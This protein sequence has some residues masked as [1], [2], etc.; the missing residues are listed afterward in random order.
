MKR[1]IG[2][3]LIE[4]LIVVAIIGILAAIAVPNFLEAQVRA[5]VARALADM[6]TMATGIETYNV[7]Y[8]T[9]PVTRR[10]EQR[11]SSDP[12]LFL[13]TRLRVLT[14]PIA[15]LATMP[16]EIFPPAAGWNGKVND[17]SSSLTFKSFDTYDYF[18]AESD[19][20]DYQY[21]VSKYSS[22][23]AINYDADSTRGCAWR[24]ASSGP[25]LW[26][27]FG[28]IWND[29]ALLSQ[30]TPLGAAQQ[31]WDYDATN[32]TTSNGDIV[33]LG[34]RIREWSPELAMD[35]SYYWYDLD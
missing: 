13:S 28:I 31:G 30:N 22:A 2:F 4:L 17:G 33:F 32:G 35:S 29:V 12:E 34:P 10:V 25:D 3:T 7:D 19:W 5:K 24:L 20:I 15:Y 1:I 18:D 26:G 27:S 21:Y 14:T 9:Y 6:R 23:T 11:Y 8:N 16:P